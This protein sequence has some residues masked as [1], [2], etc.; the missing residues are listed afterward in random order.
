MGVTFYRWTA[1]QRSQYGPKFVP[2]TVRDATYVRD[3]LCNN[4][5]EWPIREH[6]TDTAGATE[7]ICALVDLLGFRFAPRLRALHDR[8]LFASGTIDMQRSP[9]LQPHCSHR[10]NRPR[11]L[12]WWDA[13]LRTAG[14]ITLGGVPAS[15]LVQKL[16]ASPPQNALARALQAYG[17]LARTLHLF[18]WYASPEERRRF[19]RQLNKGEALHDLRALLMVANKGQRRQSRGEAFTHQALCLNLVTHAVIVWNT[20]Y[21]AAVVEQLKQEGS[22]V[23][24]SDLAH[25]WP[26]R[27]AHIN[28]YG[29]YHFNVDEAHARKGLRPLQSPGRRG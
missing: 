8:R 29:K 9:R 28:V 26:T 20:V 21:M 17:R 27:Y 16:P 22:P 24:E 19:L 6:P 18:R 5:T 13:M 2:V 3:E 15:L 23:Q 4:D 7:I 1:A 25:V 10:I 12:D 11:S 14:S